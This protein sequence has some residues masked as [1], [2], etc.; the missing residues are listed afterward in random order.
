[1]SWKYYKNII[2]LFAHNLNSIT[3]YFSWSNFNGYDY[4]TSSYFK[5]TIRGNRIDIYMIIS[6]KSILLTQYRR[7][8]NVLTCYLC[9]LNSFGH[10]F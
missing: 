1:M 8:Y 9:C 7:K 5:G 4:N 10:G 2:V 6:I 3:F